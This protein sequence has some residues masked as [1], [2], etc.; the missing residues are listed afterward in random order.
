MT[1]ASAMESAATVE[2]AAETAAAAGGEAA[3]LSAVVVATEGAGMHAGFTV[4]LAIAA[5]GAVIA[6]KRVRGGAGVVVDPAAI[7]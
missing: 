3:R 6:T 1:A 7:E 2:S 5:R 4:S